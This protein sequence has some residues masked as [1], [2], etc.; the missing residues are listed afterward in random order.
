MEESGGEDALCL[1]SV[2]SASLGSV[3]STA[4]TSRK[5]E[6]LSVVQRC[7][8]TLCKLSRQDKNQVQDLDAVL[9]DNFRS[10]LNFACVAAPLLLL[11]CAH[12]KHDTPAFGDS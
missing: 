5:P 2:K 8:Q 10:Y 7:L 9:K 1:D 3:F 11:L 6:T 4:S 12:K